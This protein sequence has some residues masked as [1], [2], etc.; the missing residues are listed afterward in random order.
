VALRAGREAISGSAWALAMRP[1][2]RTAHAPVM[3]AHAVMSALGQKRNNR[4]DR[5]NEIEE[6]APA[7]ALPKSTPVITITAKVSR[8]WPVQFRSKGILA[9]PVLP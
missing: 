2:S 5:L 9:L 8:P 1:L 4:G 3:T 6:M 7:F